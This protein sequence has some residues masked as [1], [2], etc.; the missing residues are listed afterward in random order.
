V[1]FAADAWLSAL[2]IATAA[3]TAAPATAAAFATGTVL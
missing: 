1:H 3:T 2:A